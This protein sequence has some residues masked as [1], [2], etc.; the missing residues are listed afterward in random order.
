[1]SVIRVPTEQ[2]RAVWPLA[3]EFVVSGLEG[4][5][6]TNAEDALL[7]LANNMATLFLVTE[8][9]EVLGAVVMEV[10]QYPRHRVAR[11]FVVGGKRG[12]FLEHSEAVHETVV[13]WALGLGCDGIEARGRPGWEQRARANGYQSLNA[14]M[15]WRALDVGRRRIDSQ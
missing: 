5:P 4:H 12:G 1:M 3:E 14:R 11:E 10:V 7:L 8:R 15:Y 2:V 13:E 6:W 9:D